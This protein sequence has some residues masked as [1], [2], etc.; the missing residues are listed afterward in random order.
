MSERDGEGHLSRSDLQKQY[1][2]SQPTDFL[3]GEIVATVERHMVPDGNFTNDKSLLGQLLSM[4]AS[5]KKRGGVHQGSQPFLYMELFLALS[6][7]RSVLSPTPDLGGPP[8][9]LRRAQ[10]D[11]RGP[12]DP[13]CEGN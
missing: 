11:P 9:V 8:G 5:R 1:A 2:E 3:M 10:V 7:T 6:L 12:S 4:M 13:G